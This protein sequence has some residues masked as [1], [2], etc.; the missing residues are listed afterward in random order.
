[1]FCAKKVTK[2]PDLTVFIF[3]VFVK[4]N[5][6]LEHVKK[7]AMFFH[8]SFPSMTSFCCNPMYASQKFLCE[9]A[10]KHDFLFVLFFFTFVVCRTI[11]SDWD[12]FSQPQIPEHAW[13]NK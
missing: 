9:G 11:A 4:K 12:E 6:Q 13:C 2:L 7:C 3:K 5:L 8:F 10:I 1:M